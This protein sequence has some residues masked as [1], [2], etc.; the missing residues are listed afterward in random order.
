MK[1]RPIRERMGFAAAGLVAGWR[2][3]HSFRVHVRTALAALVVLLVL[4]PAPLWWALFGL[5]AFLVMAAELI[6][7][8]VEALVD[9]LHP[10][11]HD[12]VKAIKDMMAGAVLL[13]GG[14]AVSVAAAFAVSLVARWLG[15]GGE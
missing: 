10:E 12:E 1:G 7:A 2:R 8:A 13:A 5:V 3:E 15:W 9:H 14:A 6:N 4:R 11:L